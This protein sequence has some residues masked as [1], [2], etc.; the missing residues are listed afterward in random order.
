MT[1][2]LLY[3]VML[4][5]NMNKD[6]E[7]TYNGWSNYATWKVNLEMV[8][9]VHFE[10]AETKYD[11]ISSLAEAIKE[12]CESYLGD[13]AGGYGGEG[14]NHDYAMAFI[15]DVNWYEVAEYVADNYPSIMQKN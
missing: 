15:S 5:E 10:E 3:C 12:N 6:K 9:G 13:E 8:D 2:L 7:E 11:S 4:I 14:L 1:I